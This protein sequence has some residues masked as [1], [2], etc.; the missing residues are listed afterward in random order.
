MRNRIKVLFIMCLVIPGLL[1]TISCTKE[2]PPVSDTGTSSSSADETAA[3][4]KAKADADAARAKADA[5][6]AAAAASAAA[7]A[8]L[9]EFINAN[10]LFAF[11]SDVL[12]DSAKAILLNKSAYLRANPG[13]NVTVQGHC[14]DR[15]TLEFN[16]ALGDRRAK[17]AKNYLLDLGIDASRL[18]TIS[19]GE[20]N[21]IDPGQNDAAWAKNRRAQFV[22]E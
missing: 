18:N 14:D 8:A 15:G 19:Y 22:I 7:Q 3:A 10:V 2:K 13:L 6:A 9:D 20:E 1:F 5:D 17:S 11:E 16:Q 21:P 12:D 4:A